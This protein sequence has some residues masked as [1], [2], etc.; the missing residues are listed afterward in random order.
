MPKTTKETINTIHAGSVKLAL[1]NGITSN[2]E[3]VSIF[4][5]L[6]SSDKLRGVKRSIT[7]AGQNKAKAKVRKPAVKAQP[8][9]KAKLKKNFVQGKR[10]VG[11]LR[12]S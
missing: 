3:L 5:A 8:A 2:E 11:H 10:V 6:T 4:K 12:L 9:A 1:N 7:V